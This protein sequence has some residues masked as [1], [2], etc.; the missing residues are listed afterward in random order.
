MRTRMQGFIAS[1]L[2]FYGM[3]AAIAVALVAGAGLKVYRSGYEAGKN[4]VYAEIRE[5]EIAMEAKED[6]ASGALEQDREKARTVYRTITKEVDRV[7]EKPVYRDACFDPDG[8]R[9]AN[10]AL[11]GALLPAREPDRRV[12][13]AGPSGGRE[14]GDRLAGLRPAGPGLPGMPYEAPP[15]GGGGD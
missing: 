10:A 3:A 9:L 4:E 6:A 7:V 14:G 11:A 8:V 13:P 2:F 1:P 12:P 15:V 5:T